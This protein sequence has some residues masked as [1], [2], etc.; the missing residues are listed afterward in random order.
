VTGCL[1][2]RTGASLPCAAAVGK[3]VRDRRKSRRRRL[4][5]ESLCRQW[6]RTGKVDRPV[7]RFIYYSFPP[8]PSLIISLS[9]SII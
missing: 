6:R 8:V 3:S 1:S 4:A 5:S 2:Q 9:V 7:V